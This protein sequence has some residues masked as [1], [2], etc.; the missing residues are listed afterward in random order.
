[1]VKI[2]DEM[3]LSDFI[4][5][6]QK[7]VKTSKL[8]G[9]KIELVQTIKGLNKVLATIWYAIKGTFTCNYDAYRLAKKGEKK[10]VVVCNKVDEAELQRIYDKFLG[11]KDSELKELVDQVKNILLKPH[12]KVL[13]TKRM[14]SAAQ[15]AFLFSKA[16]GLF[17]EEYIP[18]MLQWM[19]DTIE[20]FPIPLIKSLGGEVFE[21]ISK[22]MQAPSNERNDLAEKLFKEFSNKPS[23][24]MFKALLPT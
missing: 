21:I 11:E 1:M 10:C 3:K 15:N 6:Q 2:N 7:S 17:K 19:E 23:M 18:Q 5:K 8:N 4:K 22:V 20:S 13:I 12:I 9:K 16:S 24:A 14:E